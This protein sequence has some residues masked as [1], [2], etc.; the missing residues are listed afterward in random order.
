MMELTPISCSVWS[1]GGGRGAEIRGTFPT[2]LTR[3]ARASSGRT[4]VAEEKNMTSA[5]VPSDHT[6]ERSSSAS[7]EKYG[8]EKFGSRSSK[9]GGR[10]IRPGGNAGLRQ[11]IIVEQRKKG[12][13]K[14][15]ANG[16]TSQGVP[17]GAVRPSYLE[18]P[19]GY[20]NGRRAETGEQVSRSAGENEGR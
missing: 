3:P 7:G 6:S 1:R 4:G 12:E 16:I 2:L 14:N 10:G 18:R 15:T 13:E 20:R 17:K 5:R 9:D 11:G 19:A 8:R